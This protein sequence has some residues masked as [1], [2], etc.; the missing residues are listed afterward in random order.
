MISEEQ[1]NRYCSEDVSNIENYEL[2]LADNVNMWHCHHRLEV[3]SNGEVISMDDLKKHGLYWHR[4]A[5]E[6]IF[7]T[8]SEHTILHKNGNHYNLGKHL[9]E[10]TKR[11]ISYSNKCKTHSEET[12]KKM[13]ESRK[14]RTFSEEWKRKMSEALKGK[15]PSEEIR[16]KMS[17]AQKKRH[18]KKKKAA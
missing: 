1:V 8:P 6:L 13:S 16:R 15:H 2:A 18:A 7:L 4:P 17:E 9:S 12:K 5:N 3:G 11:K 14:G 10:E